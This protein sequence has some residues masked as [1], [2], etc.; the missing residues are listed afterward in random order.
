MDGAL[1]T[2]RRW[3]CFGSGKRRGLN[4]LNHPTPTRPFVNPFILH[5]S[6]VHT[7][8]L[9]HSLPLDYAI[10]TP[11]AHSHRFTEPRAS[12]RCVLLHQSK[13]AFHNNLLD[14]A[15]QWTPLYETPLTRSRDSSILPATYHRDTDKMVRQ[16]Q[17]LRISKSTPTASPDKPVAMS[18]PLAE[19]S[20]GSTRRNSPSYNQS[21]RVGSLVRSGISTAC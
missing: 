6:L 19:I 15:G 12:K 7:P 10:I 5:Q 20:S 14:G 11:H 9:L 3:V 21:T 17:P 8:S 4:Q 1:G 18:R 2:G 16:V 13:R